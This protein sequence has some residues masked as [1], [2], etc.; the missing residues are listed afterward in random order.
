MDIIA[1]RGF[2]KKPEERNSETALLGAIERGW[3]IETDLHDLDEKLVISHDLPGKG[4]QEFEDLLGK[5]VRMPK[6]NDVTFAINIKSD[7]LEALL[8][9]ML[10]K[11]PQL[12]NFF[13]FDMT[14][15]TLKNFTRKFKAGNIATR[16]SDIETVP[17]L[18]E[19]SGWVWV[20]GF[21]NDWNDAGKISQFVRDGKKV[22]LV[23]PEL[24]K[25]DKT[26]F[27]EFAKQFSKNPNVSICTDFPDKAEEFFNG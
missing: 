7:G 21:E 15:P 26:A 17:I 23:S 13:F 6:F 22:A 9:E 16:I 1:H 14:G 19:K 20:D 10:G 11:F 27:W 24:H 8:L 3:G 12:E 2:W 4:A 25:R 18:Y 5:A